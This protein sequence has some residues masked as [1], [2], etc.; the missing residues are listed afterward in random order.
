VDSLSLGQD[1]NDGTPEWLPL[2]RYVLSLPTHRNLVHFLVC[3]ELNS[4]NLPA[5]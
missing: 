1:S 3:P 5:G 2:N 4:V